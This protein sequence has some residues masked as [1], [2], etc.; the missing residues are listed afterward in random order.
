MTYKVFRRPLRPITTP[1]DIESQ[2]MA[3]MGRLSASLI[4]EISSPLSNVMIQLEQQKDSA[5]SNLRSALNSMKMLKR[6]VEA[7]RQQIRSE[8]TAV[9]FNVSTQLNDV[10]RI[11]APIARSAGVQIKFDS[12]DSARMFGDPVK[13]QQIAANILLNAVQ[14]YDGYKV[15]GKKLVSLSCHSC[16]HHLHIKIQDW[17]KGIESKNL[18]MIF[19]NFFTTKRDGNQGLGMGLFIARQHVCGYFKGTITVKSTKRGTQFL[20]K[21][22]LKIKQQNT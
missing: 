12:K 2:R 11:I 1:A 21:L 4:H 10:K 16:K 3:E 7:V 20:I 6:Y 19:S 9:I 8:S 17:G 15:E 13:F 22:P 5:S 18:P 14:A